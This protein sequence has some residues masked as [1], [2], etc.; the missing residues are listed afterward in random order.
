MWTRQGPTKE[1]PQCEH[2]TTTARSGGLADTTAAADR[3][4]GQQHSVARSARPAAQPLPIAAEWPAARPR[5]RHSFDLCS[6]T[7]RITARG[8]A[9][10]GPRRRASIAP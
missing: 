6:T 8:L 3:K 9:L 10:T 2:G 4:S 5:F 7:L 1:K